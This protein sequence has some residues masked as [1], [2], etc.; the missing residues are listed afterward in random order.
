MKS[1]PS[2]ERQEQARKWVRALNLEDDDQVLE[3]DRKRVEHVLVSLACFEQPSMPTLEV[4]ILRLK[5]STYRM[6]LK[7][8]REIIRD[9]DWYDT[10]LSDERDPALSCISGTATVPAPG[11]AESGASQLLKIVYISPSPTTSSAGGGAGGTFVRPQPKLR[12]PPDLSEVHV[13]DRAI[14]NNVLL[15]AMTFDDVMPKLDTV[16]VGLERHYNIIFRNWSTEIDDRRWYHQFLEGDMG[17]VK[18]TLSMP[19]LSLDDPTP[20]K[21][22]QVHRTTY[23]TSQRSRNSHSGRKK[24][25][26]STATGKRKKKYFFNP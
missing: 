7:G 5:G 15:T 8:W 11:G 23:S 10:F 13:D 9:A 19:H 20:V 17:T 1:N 2:A 24:K 6:T 18:A 26:K 3:K 12:N 22:I 16:I 4:N 14:V 21:V 25:H